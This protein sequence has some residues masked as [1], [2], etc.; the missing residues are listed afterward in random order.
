[1]EQKSKWTSVF[2]GVFAVT[3]MSMSIA[4]AGT[5]KRGENIPDT[6]TSY[7]TKT[8]SNEGVSNYSNESLAT[9]SHQIRYCTD[10]QDLRNVPIGFKCITSENE[11]YERVSKDK[12]GEAWK[13]SNGLIWSG[14]IGEC[15]YDKAAETCNR[16]GGR[17]PSPDDFYERGVE[18]GFYDVLPEMNANS[19]A[20]SYWTSNVYDPE[21]FHSLVGIYSF[22]S[23]Y[24]TPYGFGVGLR[25]P[26][27]YDNNPIKRSL[28]GKNEKTHT[29]LVRCV[30]N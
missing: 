14:V 2:V 12:F 13:D 6:C 17:L 28:Y 30:S 3:L 25:N 24:V 4:L 10:I 7:L 11:T 21:N 26:K 5:H 1:M 19:S 22:G 23:G 15:I 9:Q 20:A 18:K 27:N 16:I 8:N 29:Y